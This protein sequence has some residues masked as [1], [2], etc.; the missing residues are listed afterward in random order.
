MIPAVFADRVQL[1]Q[2]ILNLIKNAIEA[3]KPVVEG[4]RLLHIDTELDGA[5]NIVCTVQDS[6]A[7]IDPEKVD[8]IFDRFY[9]TKSDGLGMGLA[10]CRT[11]IEAHGGHL[12]AGANMPRGAIFRF[13][14][15]CTK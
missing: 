9:T 11:I 8:R 12:W 5:Q 1:Q 15:P 14:I 2:V 4:H 10:I 6:G 13:A 7:G 3:M